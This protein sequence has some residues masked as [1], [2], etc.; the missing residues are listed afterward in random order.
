MMKTI[1][2]EKGFSLVE[3]ISALVVIGIVATVFVTAT[4]IMMK[5]ETYARQL[6]TNTQVG[7]TVV[8][9]LAKEEALPISN[10]YAGMIDLKQDSGNNAR[11]TGTYNKKDVVLTFEKEQAFD[12]EPSVTMEFQKIN[13]SMQVIVNGSYSTPII[14]ANGKPLILMYDGNTKT[15][16]INNGVLSFNN[17]E[18]IIECKGEPYAVNIETVKKLQVI[19]PNEAFK[20]NIGGS[21]EIQVLLSSDFYQIGTLYNVEIQVAPEEPSKFQTKKQVL[22]R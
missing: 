2:S 13:G 14:L 19:V 15:L 10:E 18:P 1:Q 17:V 5:N 9:H 8:E 4:V 11:Y 21:R 6:Q 22:L 12:Q 16:H 3:V 7:Q 20:E